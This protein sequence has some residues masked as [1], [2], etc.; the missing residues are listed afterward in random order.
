MYERILYIYKIDALSTRENFRDIRFNFSRDNNKTQLQIH[1]PRKVVGEASHRTTG[2]NMHHHVLVFHNIRDS[3][4]CLLRKWFTNT[5]SS[6]S[7][8]H[9]RTVLSTGR[10]PC[11]AQPVISNVP[12]HAGPNPHWLADWMCHCGSCRDLVMPMRNALSSLRL[13]SG[14]TAW[15]RR[16]RRGGGRFRDGI[17]ACWFSVSFPFRRVVCWSCWPV[18]RSFLFRK[19]TGY[20]LFIFILLFTTHLFEKTERDDLLLW[21]VGTATTDVVR[22]TG[23]RNPS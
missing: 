14:L 22:S 20:L 18:L 4:F 15:R 21:S 7:R 23:K 10:I 2:F 5:I 1:L 6:G 9:H 19:L 3:N 13:S 8:T 12:T 16:R 17:L 11:S